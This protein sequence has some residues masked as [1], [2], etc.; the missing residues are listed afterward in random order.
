MRLSFTFYIL[1][2][3]LIVNA[4]TPQLLGQWQ[5]L[6]V[7]R[8][9]GE[10]KFYKWEDKKANNLSP[11]V[12]GFSN[13]IAAILNDTTLTP[14][15]LPTDTFEAG[16]YHFAGDTLVIVNYYSKG[17]SSTSANAPKVKYKVETLTNNQL[18]LVLYDVDYLN[19]IRPIDMYS[20]RY[21]FSRVKGWI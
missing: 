11:V 5:L 14:E 21:V 10:I 19:N 12:W 16:K 8:S 6:S 20:K 9:L 7:T 18:V 15:K 4:Q 3:G 13:G 2:T 1:L 17:E